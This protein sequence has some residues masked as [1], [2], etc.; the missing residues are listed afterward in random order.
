MYNNN[1]NKITGNR[2]TNEQIREESF[3]LVKSNLD[4]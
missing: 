2:L 3:Y 4:A 1:K